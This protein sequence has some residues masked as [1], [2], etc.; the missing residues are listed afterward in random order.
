MPPSYCD[1]HKDENLK[2]HCFDC[3]ISICAIRYIELHNA[4]KCSDI[5]KVED[6]FRKQMTSDVDNITAGVRKCR[7]ILQSVEK[8]KDFIGQITHTY[9]KLY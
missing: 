1:Q 5:N 3:K 2:I 7:Q 4:H 6:G 8:E 9:I